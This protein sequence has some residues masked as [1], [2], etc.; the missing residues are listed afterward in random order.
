MTKKVIII[1]LFIVLSI[2]AFGITLNVSGAWNLLIDSSDVVGG[3]GG[4]LI[5]SYTS[6]SDSIVLDV[7]ST[8]DD[9]D[10]WQIQVHKT[11]SNWSGGLVLS[12]IRS[13]NGIGSGTISGGNTVYLD[14][15]A[16]GQLFFDGAGDRTSID[17][18]LK[19]SG[20]TA[21]IASDVYVTTV[22]FTVIDN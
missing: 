20:V 10:S 18:Q 19:L 17:I 7:S 4:N 1:I 22:Y 9:S 6:A 2:K 5:P 14:L 8:I 13:T 3:A 16:V 15:T 21:A 12:C 11:D